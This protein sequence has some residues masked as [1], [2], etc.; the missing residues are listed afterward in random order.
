[1]SK[2][3][4]YLADYAAYHRTPG[5]IACHFIG[6]P[7]IVYSILGLLQLIKFDD[8]PSFGRVTAAEVLIVLS[9]FYYCTLDFRLA[10]SMLIATSLLDI[11]ARS[12]EAPILAG[13]AFI[14]GWVFQ[15]IGHAVFEKKSPA[16]FRNLLHLMIGPLFL[17]NEAFG[18]YRKSAETI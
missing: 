9:F 16:F 2:I 13:I 18:F 17:L 4:S 1:M 5:N 10:M 14:L 7:L 8:V 12:M 3:E 6:I 15:G 11:V